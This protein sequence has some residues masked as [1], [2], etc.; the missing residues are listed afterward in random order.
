MEKDIKI[1]CIQHLIF[2]RMLIYKKLTI[3]SIKITIKLKFQIM[4][5][6]FKLTE[7]LFLFEKIKKSWK[8]Y[9]FQLCILELM[10][11]NQLKQE[12]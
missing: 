1:F 7:L 5:C 4:F 10:N 3:L 12:K 11:K 2:L 9:F 6:I 8:K